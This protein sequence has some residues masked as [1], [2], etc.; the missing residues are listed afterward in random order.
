MAAGHE[1]VSFHYSN[2]DK[3]LEHDGVQYRFI[4]HSVDEMLRCCKILSEVQA[5]SPDVIIL[6]GVHSSWRVWVF[7]SR[8]T[9][10]PIYIQHHSE[11][12]FR[13]F[14]SFLQKRIDRHVRGY[15]FASRA[16]ADEWIRTRLI[17]NSNKIHEVFE[18]TSSFPDP[19]RKTP[20]T[21]PLRF[22]WVGRLD[23]NKDP[24]TMIDGFVKFLKHE[25]QAELYMIFKTQ[26]L[27]DD[28]QRRIVG[29]EKSI[30]LVGNISHTEMPLWYQKANFIVSTSRYEVGAVAVVE[31]MSAGCIPILTDIPAF[32]K[33]TSNGRVGLLYP[34]R[35]PELLADALLRAS[36]LDLKA[37]REKLSEF[38]EHQLSPSAIAKQMVA[39]ITASRKGPSSA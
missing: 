12:L 34:A 29:F 23:E 27:L 30:H 32:V 4:S 31:A 11:Q 24:L 20:S 21:N 6:H 39:A 1:V 28:V 25:P 10:H 5:R 15:F 13:G 9:K 26:D 14:K 7:T 2:H 8:L 35:K 37:E 19:D 17:S 38:Y 36:K 18:A 33:I 22:I 16:M 3:T